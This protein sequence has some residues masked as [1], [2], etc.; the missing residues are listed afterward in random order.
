MFANTL[1]SVCGC[2]SA[3]AGGGARHVTDVMLLLLFMLLGEE[4][5]DDVD[6]HLDGS[7]RRRT[8]RYGDAAGLRNLGFAQ[9]DQVGCFAEAAADGN[10]VT[11]EGLGACDA[12][13]L[14]L[15]DANDLREGQSAGALGTSFQI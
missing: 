6:G 12:G 1:V 2:L 15:A 14:C 5:R 8:H 3:S 13:S 4:Q 11:K 10:V 9:L 7:M